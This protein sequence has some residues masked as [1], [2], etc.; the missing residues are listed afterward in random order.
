[1]S[2]EINKDEIPMVPEIG[3]A[4]HPT[5]IEMTEWVWTDPG[6][7]R[8][9]TPFMLFHAFYDGAFANKLG[10]MVAQKEGEEDK[11]MLLVG[12]ELTEEGTAVYP[13]ARILETHEVALYKR[14]GDVELAA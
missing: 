8:N 4:E 10:I 3:K 1:L 2:E 12:V 14:P 9:P 13:L 11:H 6:D 7:P 5:G